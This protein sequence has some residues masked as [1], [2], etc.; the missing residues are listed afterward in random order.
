MRPK[1]KEAQMRIT[2][3]GYGP[4]EVNRALGLPRGHIPRLIREGRGPRITNVDGK[5][6]VLAE[7][8]AA[9]LASLAVN[10][11]LPD[12]AHQR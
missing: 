2:R 8:L 4:T 6:I 11:P 3:L 9:W 12:G 5:E 1:S 10:P 7:D